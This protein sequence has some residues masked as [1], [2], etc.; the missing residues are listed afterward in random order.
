MP[1]NVSNSDIGGC[2]NGGG[3]GDCGD[4]G[5]SGGGACVCGD[6]V[7]VVMLEVVK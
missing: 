1:Q 7:L 5:G 6:G 4:D 3:H 2:G